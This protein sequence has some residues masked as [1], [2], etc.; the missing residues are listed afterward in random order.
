MIKKSGRTMTALAFCVVVTA[1]ACSGGGREYAL[2]TKVCDVAVG[3]EISSV[4][5]DGKELTQR[6]DTSGVGDRL[7]RHDCSVSVDHDL[8][9]LTTVTET[10]EKVDPM[11]EIATSFFTNRERITGIPFSGEGAL[12]D[13]YAEITAK[14]SARGSAYLHTEVSLSGQKRLT[15]DIP[16]RRK[17]LR[18]FVIAFTRDAKH[19]YG[20]TA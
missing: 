1:S 7:Y 16:Q 9:L 11:R 18:E 5:P 10:N 13:E 14:C 17:D 12:G 20:C 2:P 3:K 19:A 4:L 8:A 6:P 15:S